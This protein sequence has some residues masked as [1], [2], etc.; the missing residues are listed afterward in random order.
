MSDANSPADSERSAPSQT[1]AANS[2]RRITYYLIG[3]ALLVWLYTLWAD[4]FTP[5]TNHGRIN[6][7]LI[8]ITPQVSGPI[9]SVSVLN[10]AEIRRGQPLLDI[11]QQPFQL[12]VNAAK[13][14]LQQATLSVR[15]DS[16]AI[17]AA[18]ANQVAAR[19]KLVNATQHAQRN[20][21]LARRNVI[22]QSTLDDSVAAEN[23][24]QAALSQ[25]TAD[26]LKA[27]QALGPKGKNNPQIKSALNRLDQALLNLSYTQLNAPA[28]GVITNMTLATGDYA[29]QG[30]PILT[31]IN[32]YHFWLTAM[33][34]ESSLVYIEKGTVVKVV[35]DAY[36]GQ[37]FHG[38]VSSVG[39]GSSGN[40]NLHVDSVNG[41][42][43]SPN[44]LQHAQRFPV[45]IRFFD[46]PKDINLRYGGR[47]T[48]SFYTGQSSLGE[49]LLDVWTWC[50]SYL[51]YVS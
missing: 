36:P 41:L 32:N 16:A 31:Y 21:T 1:E 10:N 24:A 39:W 23:S 17:E 37:I 48:V 34:R 25:A 9:A 35:L 44:G 45:N 13:L 15:A 33:V 49:S 19:V 42:F 18:K 47:A 43:D 38:E 50:W 40:G 27:E 14:A 2:A 7:Q 6:G 30:K 28:S 51:S 26:L 8:R 22:S 20:K 5:M 11:D 29:S 4:R 3:I 46:L 12:E